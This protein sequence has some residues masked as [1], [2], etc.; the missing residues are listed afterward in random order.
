MGHKTQKIIAA[1]LICP[2]LILITGHFY[3]LIAVNINNMSMGYAPGFGKYFYG[4]GVLNAFGL[5]AIAAA[6]L[7][8]NN[9]SHANRDRGN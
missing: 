6:I 8:K 4:D 3:H 2:A 1:V 7:I 9:S 5:F